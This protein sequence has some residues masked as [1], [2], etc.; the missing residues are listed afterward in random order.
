[1]ALTLGASCG[2]RQGEATGLTVDRIDFLRR[3]LTVGRQLVTPAAG[4]PSLGP[5]KTPRSYRTVPL[6]DVALEDLSRHLAVYPAS[7][8]G[9]VLH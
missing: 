4:E 6:A 3:K 5:L 9:L 2:L 8:D 1:V 7:R